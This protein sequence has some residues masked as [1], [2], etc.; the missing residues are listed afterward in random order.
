MRSRWRLLAQSGIALTIGISFPYLELAWKCRAAVATSEA[1]VWARS[2][3]PLSRWAE[4]I[5]ISPIVF[6]VIALVWELIIRTSKA[7]SRLPNEEL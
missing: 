4:P 7:T 5:I 1:C 3:M 2:F 6:A